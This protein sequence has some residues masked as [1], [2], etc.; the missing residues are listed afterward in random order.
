[1]LQLV[2]KVIYLPLA[3]LIGAILVFS[4]GRVDNEK[5]NI[6]LIVAD[7]LGYGDLSCYGQEVLKTPNI[8]R[9][10]SEGIMFTNHYTG[11]TVCAP[12]RASLLTG[13]HQGHVSVRGNGPNMILYDE[14]I[15]LAEKLKEAGYVTGAIG[16]WGV[17]HPVPPNDPDRNGFDS[18]YGYINMWH[19][20]N[21]YPEF[22]YRNGQKEK[23]EGNKTMIINGKN[24]WEDS[25]EG[26][27]VA[28][29]KVTYVHG[30]FDNEAIAF[31]EENKDTSFFLYLAYNV[32]HAN[33]EAGYMYGDGMEVPDYGEFGTT[34]W[35][36]QEKGFAKMIDNLDN[37][38]K[39][40][41]DKLTELGLEENTL[42][43]FIS[44][45]GPH[46]E[47]GHKVNF[48][49]S[50]G[51][52][53]GHKRDL[54]EGGI[55]T[56]FIAKWP[57]TI[58][59][60]RRSN[61]ISAFWDYM[62]TFCELTGVPVPATTD[63]ISFLPTL[64]GNEVEQEEHSFLYWEFYEAGGKQAIL[65]GNWKAVRLDVRLGD[66]KP[67]ELYDLSVDPSEENDIADQHPELVEEML[68][69]M[70]ESHVEIPA[71]SLY[72]QEVNADMAH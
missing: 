36:D 11:C 49:N 48:F 64:M 22:L 28:E 1:M 55:R 19:A 40:I 30:L 6:V 67:I 35:P 38:V 61:H 41:N 26:T 69:L 50:N 56:P 46:Q 68:K 4:C 24:P 33:N 16:K 17:G 20:H 42:V 51:I 71:V 18:F 10:A 31:I 23:L 63:G 29:E 2:K 37:S 65:K 45:N 3:I 58:E 13:L 5:P 14:D 54:Y 53:K 8:D 44:D 60:G 57:G 15:T 27:G 25:P 7:D 66:P 72:S 52:Y 59:A 21:F 47:G 9:M 34:E 62:P 32:P 12:S 70:E 39:I 43:M